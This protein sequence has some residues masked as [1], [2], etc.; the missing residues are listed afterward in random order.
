MSAIFTTKTIF[1]MLGQASCSKACHTSTAPSTSSKGA[2]A[3]RCASTAVSVIRHNDEEPTASTRLKCEIHPL[4]PNDLPYTDTPKRL[5]KLKVKVNGT[6]EQ[7]RFCGKLLTE[8]H[9]KQYF[10]IANLFY[11]EPVGRWHLSTAASKRNQ[12]RCSNVR[13]VR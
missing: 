3:A 9:H 4:S 12:A 11:Y 10:T 5:R 6:V 2:T 8:L 13:G 1:I 7:L